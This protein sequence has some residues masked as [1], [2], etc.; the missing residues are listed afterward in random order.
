M[1]GRS[2]HIADFVQLG[3]ERYLID[4]FQR[5]AGEGRDAI[6]QIAKSHNEGCFAFQLRALDSGRILNAPMRGDRI[7]RQSRT[8]FAGGDVADRKNESIFGAPGRVN[9]SQLL[10]RS[11]SVE[12]PALLITRKA[13]GLRSLFGW[14]PAE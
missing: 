13:I 8:G 11:P 14:T 10:A 7:A 6:A 2:L 3:P 9:S 1:K 12:R 5:Q 4:A